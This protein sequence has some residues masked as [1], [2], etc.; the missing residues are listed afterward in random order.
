MSTLKVDTILKRTGTGTITLGQ[1]G[2]TIALGSGA[3]QTGFGENNTPYFIAT[4]TGSDQSV[5][6]NTYT[7]AAFNSQTAASSGTYDTS[8]LIVLLLLVC[9][10]IITCKLLVSWF[11][12]A[13]I[14]FFDVSSLTI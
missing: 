7:K 1:S 3:S 8:N 14:P 2:D 13:K 6:D 11:C 4:M 10:C 12:Y 9:V 5:Y